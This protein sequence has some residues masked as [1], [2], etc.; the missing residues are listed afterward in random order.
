VYLGSPLNFS[1]F[2]T[3]FDSSPNRSPFCDRTGYHAT[4]LIPIN[5]YYTSKSIRDETAYLFLG[6]DL[7]QQKLPADDTKFLEM[8]HFHFEE[9]LH[10][11]QHSEI[12]DG[13]TVIAV[14]H[15]ALLRHGRR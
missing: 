4:R 6:Y 1:S 15:A 12:R 8:R 3:Q 14:L 9:V 7:I 13:I 5:I 10:M 2:L 11:V